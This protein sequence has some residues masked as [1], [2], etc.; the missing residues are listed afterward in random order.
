MSGV[1][2]TGPVGST[3]VQYNVNFE[4]QGSF[5]LSATDSYWATA[6]G[7]VGLDD[8]S[9]FLGQMQA[10]TQG[11]DGAGGVFAG[12]TPS[13]DSSFDF[14]AST[15]KETGSNGSAVTLM[16][17]LSTSAGVTAYYSYSGSA[18]TDFLDPLS[19]PTD[20]PVFN[21]FDLAGDPIVGVDS[22]L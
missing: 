12:Q 21:F 19:F 9:G 6:T 20:G 10:D 18:T 2:L 15:E 1:I 3:L 22:K 7:R 13:A 5:M 16:L 8:A 11:D 17:N 14:A 4:V